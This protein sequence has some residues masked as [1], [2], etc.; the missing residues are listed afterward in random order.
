MNLRLFFL[1]I[2]IQCSAI[3][4]YGSYHELQAPLMQGSLKHIENWP[5]Q[6]SQSAI[7][8]KEKNVAV[9]EVLPGMQT[10]TATVEEMCLQIKPAYIYLKKL[11]VAIKNGKLADVVELFKTF[12]EE[13]KEEIQNDLWLVREKEI[14]MAQNDPEYKQHTNDECLIIVRA[15]RLNKLLKRKNKLG[16][17]GWDYSRIA[18]NPDII[19]LLISFNLFNHTVVA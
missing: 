11:H 6:P 4:L 12:L 3:Q 9:L 14:E 15:N 17:S 2:M 7:K 1:S 19:E 10:A 16:Y 8:A 13:N 18:Q 5:D